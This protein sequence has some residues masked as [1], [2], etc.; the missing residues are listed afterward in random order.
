M[1]YERLTSARALGDRVRAA[2]RYLG[3]WPKVSVWHG[4]ADPT[5]R[6][7]NAEEI[8]GQ[9]LNVHGLLAVSS[10]L[11]NLTDHLRPIWHDANGDAM[12]ELF[13]SAAW[14]TACR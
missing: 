13:P 9:W 8:I 11:E 14:R 6:Q 5:V 4:S 7:S 2:S 12:I 1:F 10:H 3:P